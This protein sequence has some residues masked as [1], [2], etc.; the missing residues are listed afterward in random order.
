MDERRATAEAMIAA[1]HAAGEPGT[2]L[3]GRN[4]R[5]LDLMEAGE[6]EELEAEIGRYAAEADRLGLPHHRWYVPLWRAA[7][8]I[9]RGDDAAGAALGEEARRLGARAED[10]NAELFVRIQ[11]TQLL[12]DAGRFT[13]IDRG[14]VEGGAAESPAAWA[15]A[16]WLAWIDAASGDLDAARARIDALAP[17]GFAAVGARRQLARGPGPV[18]RGRAGGRPG[19][20][21]DPARH[22][23]P[24]RGAGRRRGAGGPLLRAGGPLPGPPGAGVRRPGGRRRPTP[25]GRSR[26]AS[27]RGPRPASPARAPAWPARAGRWRI[28]L[29]GDRRR[30]GAAHGRHHRAGARQAACAVPAS[31]PRME[32]TA[33]ARLQRRPE[34]SASSLTPTRSTRLAPG[35]SVGIVQTTRAGAQARAARHPRQRHAGRQGVGHGHVGERRGAGVADPD[36]VA[37]R[38]R[39]P[40]PSSG[41]SC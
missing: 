10:P 1:A 29:G 38:A 11:R 41:R 13:E 35:L 19:A 37:H 12:A 4:W 18:R 26:G 36:D 7:L 3:Q 24:A 30:D 23:R 31:R 40:G 15:W 5:V 9:L 32:P 25:P 39:P 16:T 8:A 34:A 28:S 14:F 22:A 20:G 27:G 33:E 6:V 2:V 21:G 17:G